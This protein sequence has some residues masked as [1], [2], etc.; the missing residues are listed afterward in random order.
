LRQVLFLREKYLILSI[1]QLLL[2][3]KTTAYVL[4]LFLEII[5]AIEELS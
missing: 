1:Q 4:A 5:P 3:E 2:E